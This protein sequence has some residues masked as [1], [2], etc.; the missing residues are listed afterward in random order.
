MC[1]RDSFSSTQHSV[2]SSTRHKRNPLTSFSSPSYLCRLA[3][4]SLCSALSLYYYQGALRHMKKSSWST[5]TQEYSSSISQ[6]HH[7]HQAI[8]QALNQRHHHH[9]GPVLQ[10]HHSSSSAAG[11]LQNYYSSWTQRSSRDTVQIDEDGS[12]VGDRQHHRNSP[13]AAGPIHRYYLPP[14][15]SS[16]SLAALQSDPFLKEGTSVLILSLIHI[17]EPPRLLSI[18]YAVFCLKKK[19]PI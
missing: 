3:S 6:I 16:V 8:Q 13:T 2:S 7:A 14:Q 10:Q 5:F 17:S 1:I 4:H 15:L 11:L 18:S 12:G 19:K 9:H